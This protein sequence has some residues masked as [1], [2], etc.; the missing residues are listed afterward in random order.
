M[1]HE[2]VAF[3]EPSIVAEPVTTKLP[4]KE[5]FVP[6][7]VAAMVPVSMFRTLGEVSTNIKPVVELP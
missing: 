6:D 3:N 5:T 1:A 2:A 4:D 7:Q